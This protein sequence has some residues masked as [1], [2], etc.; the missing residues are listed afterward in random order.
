MW[1]NFLQLVQLP[2][3]CRSTFDHGSKG[4]TGG[5]F[6]KCLLDETLRKVAGYCSRNSDRKFEEAF[7]TLNLIRSIFKNCAQTSSALLKAGPSLLQENAAAHL[8][9]EH[10]E[11][12]TPDCAH[13]VAVLTIIGEVIR[14]FDDPQ[15]HPS[16]FRRFSR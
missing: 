3:S 15:T 8:T 2:L 1:S 5:A 7:A 12:S 10:Y 4:L 14:S 16:Y 9:S 11:F 6:E 13:V